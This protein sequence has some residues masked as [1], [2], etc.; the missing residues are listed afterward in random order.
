MSDITGCVKTT[1]QEVQTWIFNSLLRTMETK[2]LHLNIEESSHPWVINNKININ[3]QKYKNKTRNEIA[4]SNRGLKR[5]RTTDRWWMAEDWSICVRSLYRSV[6]PIRSTT[7]VVSM[8]PTELTT[9]KFV[10]QTKT[11]FYKKWILLLSTSNKYNFQM[12][13]SSKYFFSELGDT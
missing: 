3:K 6:K 12:S 8:Q 7:V 2:A 11:G 10:M 9:P 1:R 13:F 5:P 4:T